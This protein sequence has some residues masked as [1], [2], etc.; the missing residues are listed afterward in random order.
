MESM[1]LPGVGALF[2]LSHAPL[3]ARRGVRVRLVG[4]FYRF[5]NPHHHVANMSHDFFVGES[6][7]PA[8][9]LLYEALAKGI[10]FL[11]RIMYRPVDFNDQ[12]GG[13]AVEVDDEGTDGVLPAELRTHE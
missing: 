7:D 6:Y 11:L 5:P 1:V 9:C 3:R 8:S 4:V 12:P 2:D 13:C 10:L